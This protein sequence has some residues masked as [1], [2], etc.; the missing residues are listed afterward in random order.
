MDFSGISLTSSIVSILS[1]A[2]IIVGGY[3]AIWAVGKVINLIRHD[4]GLNDND[5]LYVG[6]FQDND[7]RLYHSYRDRNGIEHRD[8]NNDTSAPL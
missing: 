2:M 7:G 3:A 1:F 8:Y 6:M 5:R 4:T